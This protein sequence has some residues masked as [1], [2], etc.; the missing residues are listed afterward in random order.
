[1]LRSIPGFSMKLRPACGAFAIAMLLVLAAG[2]LVRQGDAPPYALPL[3]A[4]A[5][6]A[7]SNFVMATGLID[8]SVEGVFFLD[9][10]TGMLQCWVT[11]KNT[12]AFN[13][14]FGYTNVMANVG[15]KD[16]KNPQLLMMVGN[17]Q[18][19]GSNGKLASCLIYVLN[20]A[21]GKFAVY[22]VPWN[23]VLHTKR[24][25][26]YVDSIVLVNTGM[27]REMRE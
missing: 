16:E 24:D 17:Y 2:W 23:P 13:G 1:M 8:E 19:V 20:D 21:T 25:A 12:G 4:T 15:T 10:V 5:T 9:K 14:K 18:P 26:P 6:Q 7:G 11:S 3:H 27:I 22:S